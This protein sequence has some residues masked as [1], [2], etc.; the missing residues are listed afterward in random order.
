MRIKKNSPAEAKTAAQAY[1]LPEVLISI[2][3]MV[4]IYGSAIMAYIQTDKRAEWTG[5]S[6]EAQALSIRQ[7]EQA[8]AAKWDTQSA[9]P[10]DL[11]TNIF[12][13][14]TNILDMPY[15]GGNYVYATNL[16]SVST[17]TNI[18]GTPPVLVHMFWVDTVWN[19]RGRLFTNTTVTYRAPN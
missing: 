11:S 16:T 3:I 2:G 5:Y 4:L 13:R 12:T 9:N 17:V 19:W 18:A 7:L 10:V 6:L 15:S 14:W 8:R 1:A